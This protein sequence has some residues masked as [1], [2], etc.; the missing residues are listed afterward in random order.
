MVFTEVGYNFQ[1]VVTERVHVNA[2]SPV[3]LDVEF[4]I[5]LPKVPCSLLNIDANDPTGQSQS[6]H[7]DR[8]HHVWKHR[9]KMTDRGKIRYIGRRNK[10]ELGST[11]LK[12]EHLKEEIEK[13]VGEKE[14]AEAEEEEEED[15]DNGCGSC[16][17]AGEEGECCNTC[18]D[19]KRAYK[20]KGWH[21]KDPDSVKQC[22]NEKKEQEGKDEGCN[23]HG[24]VALD[25]GGGNFHLAPGRSMDE[26]VGG[27]HDLNSIFELLMR[28]FEQWNVTHTVHKLR[29]G[30]DFPGSVNQLDGVTRNIGDSYGMYQYYFKVRLSLV[31]HFFPPLA[32]FT[33][34][35]SFQCAICDPHLS[36]KNFLPHPLII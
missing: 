3:G 22:K 23:V 33:Y 32:N 19:V 17:G 25:T 4:D 12:E 1:T 6:L 21:L 36:F 34:L 27:A 10:I 31:G 7:L 26:L 28:T 15:D 8:K 16:Y 20:I 5:S 13:A 35:C 9:I 2:T 24:V 29:F 14:E 18:D 30:D 11:L